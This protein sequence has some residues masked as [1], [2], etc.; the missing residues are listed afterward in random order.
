MPHVFHNV[1]RRPLRTWS[2]SV[3]I[4]RQLCKEFGTDYMENLISVETFHF[5]QITRE[6]IVK[7]YFD[8]TPAPDWQRDC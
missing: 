6:D 8:D 3:D 7:E 2:A 5:E 1:V 4:Y